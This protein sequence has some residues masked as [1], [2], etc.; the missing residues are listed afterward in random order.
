LKKGAPNCCK[1][2]KCLDLKEKK[3]KALMARENRTVVTLPDGFKVMCDTKTDGGGWIVIQRRVCGEVD[4]Y[5]NWDDYKNGFGNL[6]D[7]FWLGNDHIHRLTSQ[8]QYELMVDFTFNGRNYFALYTSFKILGEAEKYKL[9]V[10]GYS[11]NA[12][13]SLAWQNGMFFTTKDRDNDPYN[14]GNC[15]ITFHGAWWYNTCHQSNLNGWWGLKTF[16]MGLNWY[17]ITGHYDTATFT[18]M[19]IRPVN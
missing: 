7:T 12:G 17:N 1:D 9:Q 2:L 5:L 14:I 10:G 8:G 3:R 4:F 6:N 16:G 18:E 11:G 19:K 13:D 15:A